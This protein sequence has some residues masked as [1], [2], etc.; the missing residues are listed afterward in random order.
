MID[1]KQGENND[2]D[3]DFSAGDL[4]YTES[5]GQ[6][7]RDL[8]LADKGHIRDSP[9]CGVGSINYIQDEDREDY[10]RTVRKELSKDGQRVKSIYETETGQIIVD[11]EYE[12]S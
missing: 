6:H 2:C 12:E 10:L 3:L 7:Q 9:E 8:I 4:Q 11:A 1:Y 5:T